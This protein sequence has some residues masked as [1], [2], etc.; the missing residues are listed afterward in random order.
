MPGF[1]SQAVGQPLQVL[2]PRALQLGGVE[3]EQDPRL[4]GHRDAFADAGHLRVGQDLGELL[5]L[6]VHLAADESAGRAA[7]H[8]ADDGAPRGGAGRVADEGAHGRPRGAAD[9]GPLLG[10]VHAGAAGAGH[11]RHGHDQRPCD[12]RA[13]ISPPY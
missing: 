13:F 2:A 10:L 12:E 4:E 9:D 8:G 3:R 5:G 6:L 11:H 1:A 7:D